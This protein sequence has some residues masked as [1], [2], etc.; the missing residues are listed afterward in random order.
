MKS[1]EQNIMDKEAE[2][3]VSSQACHSELAA[4]L[5][6]ENKVMEELKDKIISL[7][8]EIEFEKEKSRRMMWIL[9][10]TGGNAYLEKD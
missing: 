3:R 4:R 8:K 9:G 1:E 5:A 2:S 6:S 10:L 7:E